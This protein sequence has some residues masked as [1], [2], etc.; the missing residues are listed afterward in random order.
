MR[1]PG[2]AVSWS[3]WGSAAAFFAIGAFP[4]HS[5]DAYGHLAQGRQIAEAGGVPRL[6]P[7]SFWQPEPQP[8][9]NYEWAYD[10]MTWLVYDHLGAA[11]LI[12]L[13]C[14]ALAALGFALVV[15]ADRLAK[16]ATLAAPVAA[17]LLVSVAPMARIRF[18]V[19]PQI[20][21]LVLPAVL[22]LGIHALYARE[23][24]RRTRRWLVLSL[25]LMHVAWV[26]MHGSHLLGLLITLLFL[27]F[28]VRTHAF[29]SMALLLLA[30]LLGTACTPF[31]IGIVT[32]ALAHVFDPMYRSVVIEWGPWTPGRPLYLLIGPVVAALL[33]LAAM[34]PVT[35]SG[36][37]GLAYGVFCVV[38]TVM[39][40]R[41][42]RFVAHQML[43]TAPFIGAGLAQLRWVRAAE[44]AVPWV[45]AIAIAASLSLAPRLE[46]FVPY[47]FS[48]PRLGHPF[49]VA[50]VIDDHVGEPRILASIQESWPLMFAVPDGRV[51]VD[52]RV[53]FYGPQFIR[54][55]TNSFSDG[56]AF[57]ALLKQ[58]D[59]NVVVVDH[60]D[61]GQTAAVEYLRHSVAWGLGQVQDRQSMFVREGAAP[62]LR[63]F[64]VL[65]PGY[66]VGRL[67]DPDV[68]EEEIG[69]EVERV[70]HH[71]SSSAI[72]SWIAGI[73][74]LRM[75]A[76]DS[77][78]AGVRLVRDDMEREAARDAYRSLSSAAAVYPGFTAI[79]LYRAMAASAACDRSEAEQA[80]ARAKYAR[81]T[82]ETTL[83]GIE[84]ALRMGAAEARTRARQHVRWLASHP[85]SGGDPWVVALSRE[86]DAR[87]P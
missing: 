25:V 16:G 56:V 70:G 29:K 71:Q 30:Q 55:V 28:S 79:E 18:T 74:S 11:A 21:G 26:N 51:L 82:R 27:A 14:V 32:D 63:P 34:R 83:V 48:E 24:P 40:F 22:L 12:V 36:R 84:L 81:E 60:T 45:L 38:V 39:A 42:L 76:R 8:W 37:Y 61:A 73:R 47:G 1:L 44:R 23:T 52:G 4:L 59:V 75:L 13:K 57:D 19:R 6:D 58:Y 49:A 72:Q 15:L 85:E 35:R 64:E 43:F 65:G 3:A 77:D 10:L 41:S 53:P 69:L 50:R 62:S 5:L 7:F 17:T 87:C 67:L 54:M 80:L 20:V 2:R 68:S 31:G 9:S 46:P 86:I 66:R 33:M 78:R